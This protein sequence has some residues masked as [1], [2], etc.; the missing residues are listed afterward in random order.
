MPPLPLHG[1]ESRSPL[2]FTS[3]SD[4]GS[5][6]ARSRFSH[7]SSGLRFE[8]TTV[9]YRLLTNRGAPSRPPLVYFFNETLSVRPVTTWGTCRRVILDGKNVFAS[10]E[11]GRLSSRPFTI[12]RTASRHGRPIIKTNM[13]AGTWMFCRATVYYQPT[14]LRCI[15]TSSQPFHAHTARRRP[16][17]TLPAL[18]PK[19]PWTLT[20]KIREKSSPFRPMLPPHNLLSS[21]SSMP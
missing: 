2:L 13:H 21:I 1:H 16:T 14:I 17:P 8:S 7:P 10:A 20:T 12:I 3:I 4:I 5:S 6:G 11:L 9:V 19:N 18:F 15:Y